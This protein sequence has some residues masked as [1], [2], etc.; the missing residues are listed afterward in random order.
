MPEPARILESLAA[1]F[2]SHDR[3]PEHRGDRGVPYGAEQWQGR[4]EHRSSQP[5]PSP[6]PLASQPVRMGFFR[7]S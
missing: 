7:Y 5:I 4:T 3:E 1:A 2:A 6:D